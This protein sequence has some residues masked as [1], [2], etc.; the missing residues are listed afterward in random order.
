[1]IPLP[2]L[3]GVLLYAMVALSQL[4]VLQ[5]EVLSDA[6]LLLSLA[7]LALSLVPRRH[8][9][10]ALRPLTNVSLLL[11]MAWSV[12]SVLWGQRPLLAPAVDLVVVLWAFK[13]LLRRNERDDIQV[14]ALS[15]LAMAVVGVLSDTLAYGLVLAGYLILAVFTL[16]VT[17]LRWVG[18]PEVRLSRS[19]ALSLVGGVV[20]VLVGTFF[21]FFTL[22]RLHLGYGL[23]DDP[24]A[25]MR[26]GLS[27]RI[28]LRRGGQLSPDDRVVLRAQMPPRTAGV[29]WRAVVFDHFD[30]VTWTVSPYLRLSAALGAFAELSLGDP[31]TL[32]VRVSAAELD[33]DV[34]PTPPGGRVLRVLAPQVGVAHLDW[35]GLWRVPGI[36]HSG[37]VSY[38][39]LVPEGGRPAP[40]APLSAWE[41]R[42]YLR[43]SRPLSP[44]VARAVARA[45]P[46]GASARETAVAIE[47][48][49]RMRMRY[50]LDLPTRGP[51]PVADFFFLQP[52]GHCEIFSTTMVVLLR[53]R[54]I[55]ARNV[56]G[57]FSDEY[58]PLTGT[59]VVRARH[60]HSWVEA[61]LPG[62]GWVRFDPTPAQLH[63]A[64]GPR[65]M[66]QQ[67]Q[68]WWQ[69][70]VVNY[71]MREQLSLLGSPALSRGS[72]M[73]AAAPR[74]WQA[75][76]L[77]LLP[78]VVAFTVLRG[79]RWL[80]ERQVAPWAVSV[81]ALLVL[82]G[83]ALLLTS[84]T[85]W[86]AAL[87]GGAVVLWRLRPGRQ[88][89]PYRR[90]V[91]T[92]LVLRLR[93][94]LGRR[95]STRGLANLAPAAL[96]RALAARGLGASA[97]WVEAY[98]ALR[99]GPGAV[100]PADV[101][102]LRRQWRAVARELR[103]A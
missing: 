23:R 70:W 92:P 27:E 85:A 3:Q 63:G 15:F 51:D 93:A 37:P 1:M 2:L 31:P 88:V 57:Y 40:V 19:L 84:W 12:V 13:L 68:G 25:Q 86:L 61:W 73:A 29:Y 74:L 54:G 82:A 34:L 46:E 33:T 58:G 16:G 99:F 98:G 65:A 9:W 102:R 50:T 60:A 48:Y 30:G 79:Q 75:L 71:A 44:Y 94:R 11:F 100:S 4:M 87:F 20:L 28:D 24:M 10:R 38:E 39:V 78:L 56:G 52:W 69:R 72:D 49:L 18:R 45:V 32:G 36:R 14:L 101:R 21:L 76:L 64:G 103:R 83:Q 35:G 17:R 97:A 55:A 5:V 89:L 96:S 80:L 6:A 95:A 7:V 8:G 42:L 22:P 47:A 41:R 62:E 90:H 43:L 77:W 81:A 53:H 67:A 91:L 26:T 66:W 59:H